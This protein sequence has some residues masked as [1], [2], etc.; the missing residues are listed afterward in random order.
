MKD[1][2]Y[3]VVMGQNKSAYLRW[4]GRFGLQFMLLLVLC[5]HPCLG[6]T[7]L[8]TD[9]G[10]TPMT[11]TQFN[12]FQAAADSWE[13]NFSDPVTIYVNIAFETLPSGILGATSAART[14]HPYSSVRA[15]LIADASVPEQAT[16]NLLPISSIPIRDIN[17]DRFA[18]SVT[19]TTANAKAL[20]LGTGLET[21]YINPPAGVDGEIRFN[22]SYVSV[23]D[24]DPSDGI[25]FG[26]IDFVGT[27]IHELGHVLGFVCVA[28]MQMANPEFVLNPNVLDFYRFF[29]VGPGAYH[30]LTLEGRRGLA[31]AAEYY[32]TS[33]NNIPFSHGKMDYTDVTCASSSGSCQASHWRDDQG[34]LMDPTLGRGILNTLQPNDIHAFDFIGWNKKYFLLEVHRLKMVKIGWFYTHELPDVP[35]F[36]GQFDNFPSPPPSD[37]IQWPANENLAMRVGFDLG[38][39]GGERSGLGFARYLPAVPINPVTL[40]PLPLVEGEVDL[41]PPGDPA[42]EIPANLSDVFIQSDLDGVP[43]SFRSSCG[44]NGCPFDPSLGQFGGYRVPG[45]ID[46]QGDMEVGDADAMITLIMLADGSGMPLPDNHNI[47]E[48][49]VESED[50]N[51]IV[52][53]AE[54]IGVIMPPEC[55][56]AGHPIPLASLDGNCFV[57]FDDFRLFAQEW[58]LCTDPVCP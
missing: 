9:I 16:V 49:S 1:Q 13:A 17:G 27:A 42:K 31:E 28:D 33:M 22:L 24:Y 47:F 53:D 57:N 46:G 36:S 21:F 12:A 56:D 32:D 20:G 3:S 14:T 54:A 41:Y 38:Y 10:P 43:F 45:L 48:N 4:Y 29:Y 35:T 52:I 11:A 2:N 7:I 44:E 30:N 19:M 34:L 55:G 40:T 23:F 25:G 37:A 51:I 6:L 26:M 39:D 18:D 15:A 50:N 8:I 5:G 58:L